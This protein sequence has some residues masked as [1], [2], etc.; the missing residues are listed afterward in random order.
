MFVLGQPFLQH[1]AGRANAF[2]QSL[3][4]KKQA[5]L[6]RNIAAK[7]GREDYVRVRL[8]NTQ[9]GLPLAVPVPGLSGLLRTLLDSHGLV[10]IDANQEGITAETTVDV[11]LF[12][13][14]FIS[15]NYPGP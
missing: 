7:Q 2:E 13:G 4:P 11:L 10:R 9:T 5:I 1:L 6:S 3:W 15:S 12:Q 14:N 8:E